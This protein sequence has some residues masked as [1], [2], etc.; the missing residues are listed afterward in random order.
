MAFRRR[1]RGVSKARSSGFKSLLEEQVALGLEAQGVPVLYEPEELHYEIPASNHKYTP[2]FVLPNGIRIETKGYLTAED[3]KKM[4]LVKAANPDLDIR[5][6][7]GR[8]SNKLNKLSPTT[9]ADWSTK[10]GFLWA[11]R[12]VPHDWVSEPS[13]N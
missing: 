11:E 10:Y 12:L 13:K 3:R 6:V 4:R 7:F 5:F 9:Y 8:A 2:D 1:A